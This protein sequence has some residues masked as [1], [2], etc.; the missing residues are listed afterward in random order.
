MGSA[1]IKPSKVELKFKNKVRIG[2]M[3][4]NRKFVGEKLKKSDILYQKNC[5]GILPKDLK[6]YLGKKIK[7]NINK[8]SALKKV[9]F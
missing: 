9:Y 5:P 8:G 2:I 3:V 1:E 7:K 4:K 6:K